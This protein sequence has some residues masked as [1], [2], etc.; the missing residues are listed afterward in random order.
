MFIKR[1]KN[2]LDSIGWLAIKSLKLVFKISVIT[3]IVYLVI[4]QFKIGLIS[5]YF[6]LNILLLVASLSG[7]LVVLFDEESPAPHKKRKTVEKY[8]LIFLVSLAVFAL[9][10]QYLQILKNLS[11]L[12]SLLIAISVFISLSLH[13]NKENYD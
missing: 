2:L 3:F 5:N 10:Y 4:E 13:F 7:I 9:S 6:D 1:N 12:I 8:L 11:Y